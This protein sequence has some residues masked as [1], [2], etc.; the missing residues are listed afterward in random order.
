MSNALRVSVAVL[1]AVFMWLA[2]P[3]AAAQETSAAGRAGALRV[4]LD[5]DWCD[6]TFLRTEIT[7][8]DY[9]RDRKDADLHVL[10]T[11][12]GTGGGGTEYTFKFIGLGRF[13]NVEQTL[14][15]VVPQTATSDERRKMVAEVLKRGFVRYVAE[16]PLGA[17]LKV[18]FA[19]PTAAEAKA[20]PKKDPWNMWFFRSSFGGSMSGET[21]SKGK[22]IR[23]SFSGNRTTK[24]LKIS[25]SASANYRESTYDLSETETYKSVS[26]NVDTSGRYVKSLGEHWAAAVLGSAS[27]ST[28]VNQDLRTRIAGGVEYDVFPYSESTRRMFTLQ[29]TIGHN[30]FDYE[31]QTVFFKTSEQ[32]I[33]H[34]LSA[35]LSAR[36]PWGSLF[37][38]LTFS[39]YLNKPDKHN[40]SAFGEADVRVFKG[41]SF[42]VWGS[43]GRPRDQLYLP[44]AG[45]TPEEILVRQRQ[46]ATTYRYSV[47]FGISYSFGSIFNNVVN[48]RFGGG[49]G[50]FF[51]F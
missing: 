10:V 4:F 29:Y 23:S 25:F 48:P 8:V 50:E 20:D 47:N 19:A 11:T 16:T 6:E 17:R 44:A 37:G 30:Y 18:T 1:C 31:Q 24:E 28:F 22:S 39:Q 26:R 2:A 35:S 49:G 13:A 45:A 9:V 34:R 41:F 14:K 46:L 7:F 51:F 42:N 32:L 43:F 27:S 40:F 3:D 5:C 15:D 12:Q 21:S 38:D 36:Q 33:D